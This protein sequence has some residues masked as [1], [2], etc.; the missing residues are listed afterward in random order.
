M[1]PQSKLAGAADKISKD[2]KNAEIR[3]D[4]GLPIDKEAALKRAMGD[5]AFLEELIRQFT[6]NLPDEIN[7]LSDALQHDD[8]QIR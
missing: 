2:K 4:K 8:I 6:E 7:A 5:M 1:R 3:A